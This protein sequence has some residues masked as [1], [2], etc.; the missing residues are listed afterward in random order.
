MNG[1][2]D[3]GGMHGFGPILA[4]PE[5]SEPVFHADWE[6][7]VS[8]LTRGLLQRRFWSL[9]RFRSAI[10]QQPPIEYLRHTYYENW[11]GAVE[12][13]ALAHGLATPEELD[14]GR[15]LRDDPAPP[16]AWRPEGSSPPSQRRYRLGERVR[17][18]NRH[19]VG[20]TRVP[21]YVRGHVGDVVAF[22]GDEPLP[23]QAAQNICAPEHVY[24][25]RFDSTE[26]WGE[27]APAHAVFVDLWESY[28]EPAS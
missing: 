12:R 3:L 21:R 2:H 13:L 23:E 6:R 5:Q 20:H 19:P 7:T 15:S 18:S 27:A 26:L 24:S 14:A 17:V 28:L 9:D 1:A 11:L 22:A 16:S 25:V 8:A 4:E 10:E